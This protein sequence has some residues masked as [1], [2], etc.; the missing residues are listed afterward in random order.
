M[1]RPG[2]T[3][4]RAGRG[5]ASH[6]G[7]GILLRGERVDRLKTPAIPP[8]WRDVWMCPWPNGHIQATGVDAAGRRQYRYHDQWRVRGDA[9]E[10]ERVLAISCQLP[11]ARGAVVH[12]LHTR[13]L[14]RQLEITD[15]P[16][17]TATV[18]RQLLQR[19]AGT[20][21]ELL[22]YWDPWLLDAGVCSLPSA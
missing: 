9:A 14:N 21:D 2:R 20:G 10:P 13:G 11:G 7:D 12:A 5:F 18:V 1:H 4:R 17:A 16:T 22:G 19:P 6:D 15:R 8:A 3:R